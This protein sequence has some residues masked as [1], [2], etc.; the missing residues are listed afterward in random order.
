MTR[1]EAI[2]IWQKHG[3]G[4]SA[5]MLRERYKDDVVEK[6][7][8]ETAECD[9]DGFIALGLL[10]LE[11]PKS[12]EDRFWEAVQD[13]LGY[14]HESHLPD[15]LKNLKDAGLR[16]VEEKPNHGPDANP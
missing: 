6:E 16:I 4:K 14:L 9:I 15:I 3:L 2:A 1:D 10:Q 11:E 8:R 12:V 7:I 5:A 13:R